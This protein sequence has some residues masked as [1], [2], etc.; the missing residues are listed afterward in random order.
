MGARAYVKL[1][2]MLISIES[3]QRDGGTQ[4]R[5]SI[6]LD[7][8][9]EYGEEMK[10][11]AKFPPVVAFYDGKSYWLA[12][13]FHR[14]EGAFSA[15]INQIE[16]EVRQ[17]TL[18]DAQWYSFGVNQAHGLRRTNE[19]KKRAVKSAL[20]HPFSTDKS[21]EKI[22]LHVGC[23]GE[24]VRR[25][26]N[27]MVSSNQ[28]EDRRIRE[29]HRGGTTYQQDIANIGKSKPA[30]QRTETRCATEPEHVEEPVTA[31]V[32]APATAPKMESTKTTKSA[33]LNTEAARF[34]A[35]VLA[36][37]WT[38]L[39]SEST[40]K[41]IATIIRSDM[42]ETIPILKQASGFLVEI[43]AKLKARH[44]DH[45]GGTSAPIAR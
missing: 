26:R 22:A 23:S 44:R 31:R 34:A 14:V 41:E 1:T 28:L 15:D 30:P 39:E 11:G 25:I 7:T 16:C 32:T 5:S 10:A 3:L 43:V 36:A 45:R 20:L 4:P 2:H 35:A 13:G 29:V 9:Y 24:W 42:R 38:I 19:D 18:E 12:D 17:G 6:S 27:E 33:P 40:A 8:A 37:S 21:D